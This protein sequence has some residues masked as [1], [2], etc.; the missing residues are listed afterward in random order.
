MNIRIRNLT[1]SK[2]WLQSL[3]VLTYSLIPGPTP[4]PNSRQTKSIHVLFLVLHK[5]IFTNSSPPS[6]RT[7]TLHGRNQP[8]YTPQPRMLIYFLLLAPLTLPPLPPL[9][10]A[11]TASL[12]VPVGVPAPPRRTAGGLLS[13]M[14]SPATARRHKGWPNGRV[15]CSAVSSPGDDYCVVDFTNSRTR[16]CSAKEE[17]RKR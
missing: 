4:R 17:L 1:T 11:D 3:L 12:L 16:C 2:N 9:W 13:T 5:I 6:L 10:A 7:T 15:P 14:P 8:S